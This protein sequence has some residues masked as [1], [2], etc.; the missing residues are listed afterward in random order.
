MPHDATKN[1]DQYHNW[2]QE[3][4]TQGKHDET[5]M[6]KVVKSDFILEVRSMMLLCS[7]VCLWVAR[8]DASHVVG[9][10]HV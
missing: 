7:L 8:C 5:A 6:W 1:Y 9:T 4:H 10:D 3:K 2:P